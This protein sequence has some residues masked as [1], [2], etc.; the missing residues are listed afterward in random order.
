MACR[1]CYAKY[2]SSAYVSWATG[3][4]AKCACSVCDGTGY[5]VP[6][7]AITIQGGGQV[8][9]PECKHCNGTGFCELSD[10]W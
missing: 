4:D 7:S 9:F 8:T 10:P 3:G 2:T 1:L 5:V 6:K